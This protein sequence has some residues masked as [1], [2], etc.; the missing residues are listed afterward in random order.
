MNLKFSLCYADSN[1]EDEMIDAYF[2]LIEIY[3]RTYGLLSAQLESTIANMIEQRLQP[4]SQLYKDFKKRK[5][6]SIRQGAAETVQLCF[7]RTKL[8]MEMLALL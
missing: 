5:N 3:E 8:R 1:A 4:E 6:E 2:N 7:D